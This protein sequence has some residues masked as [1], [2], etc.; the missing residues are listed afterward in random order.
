MDTS[1]IVRL[2]GKSSYDSRALSYPCT[3]GIINISSSSFRTNFF[4][5]FCWCFLSLKGTAT[6]CIFLSFKRKSFEAIKGVIICRNIHFEGIQW[7]IELRHHIPGK[8]MI[9]IR[10]WIF[11]GAPIVLVANKMD[12]FRFWIVYFIVPKIRTLFFKP[13]WFCLAALV[14]DKTTRVFSRIQTNGTDLNE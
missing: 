6:F 4:Q 8:E 1:G 5:C 14:F 11:S 12:L 2:D 10:N 3:Q 9:L 7:V 13:E